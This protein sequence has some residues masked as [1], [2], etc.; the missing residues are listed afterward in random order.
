MVPFDLFRQTLQQITFSK[1]YLSELQYFLSQL[2]KTLNVL[3]PLN[4]RKMF[5]QL[6]ANEHSRRLQ[7][8]INNIIS[9]IIFSCLF[10]VIH[11]QKAFATGKHSFLSNTR[12]RDSRFSELE[13]QWPCELGYFEICIPQKMVFPISVQY[14]WHLPHNLFPIKGKFSSLLF[15]S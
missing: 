8:N 15:L 10:C 7:F 2:I 6:T 4:Q 9:E 12:D 14:I 11:L 1:T 13:V 3:K 5:I